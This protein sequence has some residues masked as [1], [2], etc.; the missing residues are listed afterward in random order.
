MR[1]DFAKLWTGQ[2]ISE[3]GS[4]ITRE[5]IPLT[6]LLTLNATVTQMGVLSAIGSASVL[7]FSLGAGVI[8]DRVKKRPL[9]IATDLGRASLL[10]AVPFAAF[11][12]VLTMPLLLAVAALAGVLTVLFDVAY[13]SYLPLLVAREQLMGCN[14]RLAMSASSAEMLGPALTGFLVQAITAPVA[15][16]ADAA[17]FVVSAILVFTIRKPEAIPGKQPQENILQESLEGMRFIWAH[18]GL[19]A[20][21]LRSVTAFLAMGIIFPLY[22]LNAIRVVHLSTS[23]LGISIALGGAGGLLG[24]TIADR[25]SRHYGL[26]PTFFGSALLSAVAQA[27][28][29]LSS[30]FPQAGFPLLCVQQFFGDLLFAVFVVNETTIRQSLAP[31]SVIGRVN[32]AMQLATRGMLPF[33]ALAGGAIADRLGVATTLWIAVAGMFLSSVWLFPLC[34][35]PQVWEAPNSSL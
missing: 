6:A 4:R 25:V 5:G 15:I 16:L 20:L 3:V 31:A 28:I 32:A 22:M 33:G 10:A 23:A 2:T 17:S 18:T 29:P 8:T 12:H 26:G 35:S 13:Q 34:T 14:R 1:N 24:A 21:L 19:R 11:Q 9:M 7:V 30:Q 27:F